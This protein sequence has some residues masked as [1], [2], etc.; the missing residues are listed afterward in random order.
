MNITVEEISS[1][2]KKVHVEIPNDRVTKEIESFYRDVGR[3]AKIKGFRPGKIPR[4][5]L[6]RYFKDY[7]K[8][9]VIQKLIQETYPAAL[10]EKG[11]Q[12]VSPPVIDPGELE[13]GKLFQYSATVE[14]KPEINLEGYTGLTIGGK[15][16]SAKEEEVEE[17]LKGLQ[18]LHAQLRAVP[19]PRA[20]QSGDHVIFDYDARMDNRPLEEGKGVDFTVEVG[21]GRF[22]PELEEKMIGL[23]PDEG[24]EIEVPFPEDYGYKKWAGKTVSFLIKVKEIKEKV[25]PPLDDEFA[26]DLGDYASLEDLKAK[27]KEEIEKEKA[28]MLDRHL[29]DQMIDQLIQANAFDIPESMVAEQTKALVSDTKLRLASQGIAL[30]NLNIPEEKLQEDYREV[31]E[32]QVRTYLILEKIAAQEGISVTDEDVD[33]RLQSVSERTHQKFDVVKRYYEKNGLIPDLKTGILTDKTLDFLLSK[34]NIS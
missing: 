12:P 3:Q 19:E 25:L 29:K 5:I 8:S 10:S 22:I 32:K 26:K 13:S 15:K 16:E 17:R 11:L 7:V 2:K 28:A 1:I 20:V 21:S 14:V 31:A 6:E 24:K 30:K 4:D 27:L 18:N 9:E 23:K 33:E 34:A